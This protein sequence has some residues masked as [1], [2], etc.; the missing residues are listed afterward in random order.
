MKPVNPNQ[1]ASF[2]M[3]SKG[4]HIDIEKLVFK[5]FQQSDAGVYVC[6]RKE[7]LPTTHKTTDQNRN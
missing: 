3:L 7:P 6:E 5:R 2:S 4:D 1:V